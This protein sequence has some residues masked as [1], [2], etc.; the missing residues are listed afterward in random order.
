[1]YLDSM[2]QV[3]KL[4]RRKKNKGKGGIVLGAE[5][6]DGGYEQVLQ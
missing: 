3:I 1:M 2:L 5:G 6:T 4:Q